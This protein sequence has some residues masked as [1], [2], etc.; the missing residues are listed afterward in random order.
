MSPIC[1]SAMLVEQEN[2][3]DYTC[4]PDSLVCTRPFPW[5]TD[6]RTHD[7]CSPFLQPHSLS[8]THS[9]GPRHCVLREKQRARC[10]KLARRWKVRREVRRGISSLWTEWRLNEDA[11]VDTSKRAQKSE[12]KEVARPSLRGSNT[13]RKE[14]MNRRKMK[15]INLRH[16]TRQYFDRQRTWFQLEM[17]VNATVNQLKRDKIEN[18]PELNVSSVQRSVQQAREVNSDGRWCSRDE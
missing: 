13:N 17:S 5:I 12:W 7:P 3:W 15:D 14:T 16:G 1:Y 6:G 4:C 9:I 11:H 2:E 10:G 8:M 18:Q